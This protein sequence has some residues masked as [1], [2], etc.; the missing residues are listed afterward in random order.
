[1]KEI[2]GTFLSSDEKNQIAYYIYEPDEPRAVIQ[3]SHG[4]CEYVERYAAHAEY[5]CSQGFVFAGNDHLGHG[6]TAKN[7]EELGFIERSCDLTDDL[8]KFTDILKERYPKLPIFLLGHSMGSFI[9]RDY[10]TKYKEKINGAI[11]SGTAGPGDPTALGKILASL[12]GKIYGSHHRSRLLF[13]MSL[14]AYSKK[15]G[16]D[17][18]PE[19]W[20]SSDSNVWDAYKNDKFCH[21][22]FTVHGYR[23]LFD[24]LGRVSKKAWAKAVPSDLPVLIVSGKDDPVGKFGKGV[25]K[26]EKRLSDAGVK[27]LSCVIF[28]GGRHELFNEAEPIRSES[29]KTVTDWINERI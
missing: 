17:A 11:L 15:F 14:G 8:S 16:K 3:L 18:S 7:S 9:L 28:E 22:V 27:D 5:F 4:M 23:V 29:Y 21:F 1:V 20:I 12:L 26:A 6:E 2:K 13:S 25:R 10:M 24:V 19:A